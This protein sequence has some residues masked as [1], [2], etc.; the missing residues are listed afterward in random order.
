RHGKHSMMFSAGVNWQSSEVINY[1][2]GL[3]AG[4]GGS[5]EYQ[6]KPAGGISSMVRFDWNYRLSERWS[7]RLVGAYRHLS[8]EITH[9]PIVTDNKVITAFAGGMYHF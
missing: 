4:E 3:E 7:L 5:L 1:Y 2:Y 9:S 6:Y 8:S